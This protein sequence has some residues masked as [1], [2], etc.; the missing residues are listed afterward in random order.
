MQATRECIAEAMAEARKWLP[1]NADSV[2]HITKEQLRVLDQVAYRFT[3][4]QDTMGQKVL[5]AVLNW[6]RNPLRPTQALLKSSIGWSEWGHC[7]RQ[8]NR[9][10]FVQHATQLPMNTPMPLHCRRAPSTVFSMA[11]HS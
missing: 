11:Q 9:K 4:L 2:Q 7:L 8:N 5:P 6:R 1:F 10:N 3:K